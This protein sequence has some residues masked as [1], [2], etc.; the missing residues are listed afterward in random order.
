MP[1][2]VGADAALTALDHLG[3]FVGLLTPDGTL[4]E[5]NARLL[6]R[7]EFLDTRECGVSADRGH[8]DAQAGVGGDRACDHMIAALAADSPGLAGDH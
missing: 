6:N 3:H 5:A 4:L 1:G 7:P 2:F 8:F